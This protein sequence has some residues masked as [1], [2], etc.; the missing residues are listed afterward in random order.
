[1]CDAGAN[2][3]SY[4]I[5]VGG[6]RGGIRRPS[7][8]GVVGTVRQATKPAPF[9]PDGLYRLLDNL[10]RESGGMGRSPRERIAQRN[11][12]TATLQGKGDSSGTRSHGRKS[13]GS[14]SR[15][16]RTPEWHRSVVNN[17]RAKVRT[18]FLFAS[19]I[20]FFPSICS[21]FHGVEDRA[22]VISE[23][24][25][26]SLS[27]P[28]PT[29]VSTG[30][31]ASKTDHKQTYLRTNHPWKKSTHDAP[32]LPSTGDPV[33]LTSKLSPF[34]GVY[35]YLSPRV[36]TINYFFAACQ[37]SSLTPTMAARAASDSSHTIPWFHCP[38][39]PPSFFCIFT[40]LSTTPEHN[41]TH[42]NAHQPPYVRERRS[43][44]DAAQSAR[45]D[46]PDKHGT[47]FRFTTLPPL[48][49]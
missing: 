35:R 4:G 18:I 6:K 19:S 12:Q 40:H 42:P 17:R 11:V 44:G 31:G 9:F 7:R 26:P 16:I 27:I 47:T 14:T 43:Q 1:M 46:S 29:Y 49:P 5:R 15:T 21:P 38:F 28:R 48:T 3:V 33:Y 30:D 13:Q 24:V 37:T 36:P 23:R 8:A 45:A 20:S 10:H 41:A 32:K 22:R 34:F 2:R 25:L 39:P